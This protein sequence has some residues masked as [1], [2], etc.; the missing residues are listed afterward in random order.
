V[1]SIQLLKGVEPELDQNAMEAL[2]RWRFRPA[3]RGGVPVELEAVVHIPF[4]NS[5]S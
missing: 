4:R 1:D 2:A 5:P 3:M